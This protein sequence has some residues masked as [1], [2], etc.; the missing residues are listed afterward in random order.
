MIDQSLVT[1][2]KEAVTA[3][4]AIVIAAS[5]YGGVKS[6]EIE[7]VL[8]IAFVLSSVF[9]VAL[10]ATAMLGLD[11]ASAANTVVY[12]IAVI[13][14]CIVIVLLISTLGFVIS[15]I[16]AFDEVSALRSFV[17]DM[18]IWSRSEVGLLVPIAVVRGIASFLKEEARRLFAIAFIYSAITAAYAFYLMFLTR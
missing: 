12:Y 6:K 15:A 11:L 18:R 4:M 14:A 17:A 9:A 16:I 8:S 7:G 13:W 3:L 5:V 1:E 2:L 10:W